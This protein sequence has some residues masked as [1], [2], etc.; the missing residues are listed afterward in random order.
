LGGRGR[1]ISE[2]EASLV[3]RVSSRTARVIQ[4]TPVLKNKKTK[5]KKKNLLITKHKRN[6]FLIYQRLKI[7]YIYLYISDGV[8]WLQ[9]VLCNCEDLHLTQSKI[10]FAGDNAT[11]RGLDLPTST[12]N[13][14][15]TP[16]ACNSDKP[17]L[18]LSSQV[19]LDCVKQQPRNTM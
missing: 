16:Q 19:T 12:D 14:D 18:R 17:S 4:R 13:Q 6:H 10:S 3:Y 9:Y 1:Q 15:N 8:S 7:I 11:H 5:T 2:F